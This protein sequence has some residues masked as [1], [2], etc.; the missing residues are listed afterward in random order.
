MFKKAFALL[1]ALTMV[2]VGLVSAPLQPAQAAPPGSAF[3][4]GLIISDS[5]FFD[6]GSMTVEEIQA[7]LDSRVVDC[8]ATDTA[9]DCLKNYR[10]DIPETPATAEGQV[11]PCAAIPARE[12]ATAAEVIHAIANACGI[13]PKVLIVTLQ[14][15]QG[16]V[17]STK[18]TEYM[19]R[20]A[21]GFGCPDADPAICGKVFVGLF[22]QL[23]R[24]ARQFQWYGN[25]EGSFTYWKPGRTV[26]MRYHPKSSCGTKTF[27]L[28]N[29]ATANLYYYTPYTP[30]DAALNNLYGTGDSCSAYGNRNFWRFFHDWFGSPIGGGYL[31]K[32]AGT[33]TY[34]IVNDQRYE[35]TDARLLAALRP[36]GPLGEISQAYLESFTNAGPMTQVVKDSASNQSFLL[37]DG[38]KYQAD[39]QTLTQFGLDCNLSVALSPLQL[40][41]FKDGGI[42]TRLVETDTGARYW[43]ENSQ[44]RVVAD[45]IALNAAGGQGVAP[46]QLTLE[47]IPTLTSGSPLAS[48]LM[49]FEVAGL[50]ERVVF[51]DSVAYRIDSNLARDVDLSQWF[52]DSGAVV[53]LSDIEP[54]LSEIKISTFVNDGSGAVYAVTTTGK[55]RVTTPENWSATSSELPAAILNKIPTLTENLADQ[56]VVRIPGD[57]AFYFVQSAEVRSTNSAAMANEFLALL[58]QESALM[59]PA[60]VIS[61]IQRVGDALAPGTLVK[62]KDSSTLYLVDD[63][64]NRIKMASTD[65][66]K[67]VTD[68]RTYTIGKN[69]M[70]SLNLRPALTTLKVECNGQI[71]ILDAGTLHPVSSEV[72]AHF[73]GGAYKLMPNTCRALNLSS[74]AAG[75]FLQAA[76]GARY[77]IQEGTKTKLATEEFQSL[78]AGAPAALKVS[79]YFLGRIPTAT[80]DLSEVEL[81]SWSGISA[82]AFGPA[83]FSPTTDAKPPVESIVESAPVSS[84]SSGPTTPSPTP[85]APA[86]SSPAQNVE[87]SYR[88]QAGDTLLRIAFQFGTTMGVLQEY[89]GISNPNLIRIGQ[90]IRIPATQEQETPAAPEQAPEPSPE[91]APEAEAAPEPQPQTEQSYRVQS[92]D[93]LIRIAARFGISVSALQEYNNISNP[94]SIRIGQLLKVPTSAANSSVESAAPAEPAEPEKITYTVRAGDTLWSISRKFGVSSAAIA[95][96]NGINNVN[97]I[98]V[99]QVIRIVG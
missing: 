8:R 95:E 58:S 98:R 91:P 19:Y 55:A 50:D 73:P 54:T 61:Q 53:E 32:A 11:G 26:A 45:E 24:A 52:P 99:G 14:K 72:A 15:E 79:N 43:I 29:Q 56:V 17:T 90:V 84:G 93:T 12:Q 40:G 6:F 86:P 75:Q 59:V 42:L 69:T 7:F 51:H 83:V 38:F 18:P 63:L 64:T 23:Y 3:D 35:V 2:A 22:N 31:L 71:F 39:C 70:S 28:Q 49:S 89:N 77:L 87:Q 9:I 25:P 76:D 97:F 85:S 81:A 68:A 13:N 1:S 33:A 21:M 60:T 65:Q 27:V 47:Q 4:P 94:N 30:N 36:L 44:T 20:A 48:N 34:L 5:V 78:S 37:V 57:R 80:A 46:V 82:T 16:L 92:G 88:V 96:L 74:A 67:S 41:A 10:I 62:T 66:A